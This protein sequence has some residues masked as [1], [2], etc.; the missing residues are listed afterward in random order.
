MSSRAIVLIDT[1]TGLATNHD[2]E[3][4]KI[5]SFKECALQTNVLSALTNIRTHSML[6]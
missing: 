6:S 4:D 1:R 2:G 5:P 3:R